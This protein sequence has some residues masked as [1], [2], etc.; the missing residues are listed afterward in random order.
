MKL[1]KLN[2]RDY[3]KLQEE[4]ILRKNPTATLAALPIKSDKLGAKYR[5]IIG[6]EYVP[7]VRG[8]N[9]ALPLTH[10]TWK[11]TDLDPKTMLTATVGIAKYG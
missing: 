7:R 6:G 8:K 4:R 10:N 9:E 11:D 3:P 1:D 5:K 2:K